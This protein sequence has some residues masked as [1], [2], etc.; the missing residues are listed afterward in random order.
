[1]PLLLVPW[2]EGQ[3]IGQPSGYN[4]FRQ[5]SEKIRCEASTRGSASSRTALEQAG[6]T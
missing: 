3:Q 2:K 1:M 6:K 5:K 4:G